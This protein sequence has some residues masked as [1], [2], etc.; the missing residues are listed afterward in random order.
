M[1]VPRAYLYQTEANPKK[2]YAH[3]YRRYRS[4]SQCWQ[5]EATI[6]ESQFKQYIRV[7]NDISR[8]IA[9]AGL[10]RIAK[11]FRP[12]CPAEPSKHSSTDIISV[13]VPQLNGH[14]E[15]YGAV[16]DAQNHRRLLAGS[17]SK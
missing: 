5:V 7:S 8:E 10:P 9:T 17:L 15:A 14:D 16:C 3:L 6:P 1:R 2:N 11:K 12:C 4:Q 13:H